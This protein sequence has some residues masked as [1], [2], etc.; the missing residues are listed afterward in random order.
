VHRC[1]PAQFDVEDDALPDT[2]APRQVAVSRQALLSTRRPHPRV[3]NATM[4]T[5]LNMRQRRSVPAASSF[6]D[7]ESTMAILAHVGIMGDFNSDGSFFEAIECIFYWAAVRASANFTNGVLAETHKETFSTVE[8]GEPPPAEDDFRD[9]SIRAPWACSFNATTSSDSGSSSD[10]NNNED[11]SSDSCVYTVTRDAQHGLYNSLRPYLNGWSAKFTDAGSLNSTREDEVP[12]TLMRHSSL[13]TDTLY[14]GWTE[15]AARDLFLM[16]TANLF[17]SN[18]DFFATA[19]LRMTSLER[20]TSFGVAQAENVFF[21]VNAQYI[22]LPAIMLGLSV[23]FFL[24]VALWTRKENAWRNS[25]LPLLYHGLESAGP[26]YW[27]VTKMAEMW[28]AAGAT[29]VQ[30]SS[31]KDGGELRLQRWGGDGVEY[32]RRN[33]GV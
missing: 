18:L 25:Q 27:E 22:L 8:N 2:G 31:G 33:G 7:Q 32:W 9:V 10:S 6:A 17:F 23:F 20:H 29:E 21:K 13:Q 30:M 4:F 5:N 26:R 28:E 14:W 15:M 12:D 11:S 1:V 3:E 24:G 19:T 16:E